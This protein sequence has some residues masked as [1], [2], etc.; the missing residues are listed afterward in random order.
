M[1]ALPAALLVYHASCVHIIEIIIHNEDAD[2]ANASDTETDKGFFYL[3]KNGHAPHIDVYVT[4]PLEW[5]VDYKEGYK[6]FVTFCP[7]SLLNRNS[8]IESRILK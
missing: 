2:G 7:Y 8:C 4:L 5:D 1:S 6:I 3:R